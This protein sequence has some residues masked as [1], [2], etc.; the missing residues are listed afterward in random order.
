MQAHCSGCY[1][2]EK[3]DTYSDRTTAK[4]PT[5]SNTTQNKLWWYKILEI[6]M[7]PQVVP[8]PLL[9]EKSQTKRIFDVKQSDQILLNDEY[10]EEKQ[11]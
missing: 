5:I 9:L 2:N 10:V 3:V 7:K 6:I 1:L 11:K 8:A 4:M